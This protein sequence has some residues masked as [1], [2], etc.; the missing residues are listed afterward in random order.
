MSEEMSMQI[1]EQKTVPVADVD[2][3]DAGRVEVAVYVQDMTVESAQALAA[4]LTV[5]AGEAHPRALPCAWCN[6]P[7]TGAAFQFSD[8][9]YPERSCGATGHG[10]SFTPDAAS[11]AAFDQ[12]M[13]ARGVRVEKGQN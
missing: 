9:T 10:V 4:A 12:Q 7:A 8:G 6:E 2:W 1:T 11:A 3:N 13:R 5:M